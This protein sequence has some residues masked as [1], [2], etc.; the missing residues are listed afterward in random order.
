MG[1]NEDIKE[2]F[3]GKKLYGDDFKLNEIKKWVEEEKKGYS[4]LLNGTKYEYAYHALNYYHG[5]KHLESVEYKNVLGIGSA[6]GEEFRPIYRKVKNFTIIEPS[7]V[8]FK[9]NIFGVPSKYKKPAID[10][11]LPFEDNSFDLIICL[12]VLHHIPNV[13]HVINE[14]YR[15][16][17]PE[18]IALVREPVVSMGDWTETRVGLTKNERGIPLRCMYNIVKDAGFNIKRD[19]LCV[20]PLMSIM[21][22]L[23]IEFP[24]YNSMKYVYLDKILSVLFKYNLKYH[25]EN[26]FKKLAPSSIFLIL[27]K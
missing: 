5:F 13:T 17:E 2:F 4:G 19:E 27:S 25:P 24:I 26:N 9:D 10:G 7:E 18:G 21:K 15:C 1:K 12:G 22:K 11:T 8:F 14:M 6:Y 23:G 20:F 16:L 3:E